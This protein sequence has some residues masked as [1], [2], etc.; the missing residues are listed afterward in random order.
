L[1]PCLTAEWAAVVVLGDAGSCLREL[2]VPF[3]VVSTSL[4]DVGEDLAK[5]VHPVEVGALVAI[6][7][8]RL[9]TCSGES[10]PGAH[11]QTV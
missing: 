4:A 7:D 8:V 9:A 10:S 2:R 1:A 6:K 3:L 5:V 11:S